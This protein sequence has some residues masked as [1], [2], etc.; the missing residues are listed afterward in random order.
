MDHDDGMRIL[1]IDDD[2][3]LRMTMGMALQS[4]QHEPVLA[5]SVVDGLALAENERFDV[6]MTDMNMPGLNG[7]EAVKALSH[8][9]PPV[10][11]V[12][13]SGGSATSSAQDYSVLALTMGAHVFLQK[14]FKRADVS[15]AIATA[16][17]RCGS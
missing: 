14:P 12:A 17:A 2:N 9:K 6:V 11:I 16:L 4:L 8:I 3:A 1:V 7:L 13:M 10:A 15:E 5:A